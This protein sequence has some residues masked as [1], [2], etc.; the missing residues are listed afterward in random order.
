MDQNLAI[1]YNLP[2]D[3]NKLCLPTKDQKAHN[4][5]RKRRVDTRFEIQH[6]Q[7]DQINYTIE[8][9]ILAAPKYSKKR[10][11]VHLMTDI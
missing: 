3:R 9:C 1:A 11:F 8:S 5:I 10:S 6:L 2:I 7:I 4:D